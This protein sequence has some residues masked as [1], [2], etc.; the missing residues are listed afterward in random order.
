M[1]VDAFDQWLDLNGAL[2]QNH[3]IA[4]LLTMGKFN[5][6]YCFVLFEMERKRLRLATVIRTCAFVTAHSLIF[7]PK[8]FKQSS[9]VKPNGGEKNIP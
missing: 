6:S 2:C 9:N 1:N 7:G 4:R 8:F 5:Y 3:E